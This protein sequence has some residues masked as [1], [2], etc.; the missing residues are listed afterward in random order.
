MAPTACADSGGTVAGGPSCLP[1]PCNDD[2]EDT[3]CCVAEDHGAECDLTSATECADHHG[4]NMGAGSCDPNPCAAAPPP[5]V[6]LCCVA[7]EEQGDDGEGGGSSHMDCEQLTAAHCADEGG[8]DAGAGS[9][10]P[11]P[12]VGSPSGA[13]VESVR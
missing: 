1:D 5:T 10:E 8:T 11:N 9:C 7:D 12:C 2:G 4:V 3:R 13:F 6:N